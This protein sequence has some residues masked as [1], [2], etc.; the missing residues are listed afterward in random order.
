MT[1]RDY[2]RSL[3]FN[4]GERGRFTDAMKHAIESYDGTFDEPN[5]QKEHKLGTPWIP[6]SSTPVRPSFALVGW[7]KWDTEVR[8]TGCMKCKAHMI[9]CI[10]PEGIQAPCIVVRSDDPLVS[11]VPSAQYV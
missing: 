3:G 4:V 7:T 6:Y 2:L 8:F 10:C 1:K 5:S 9:Y 11:V